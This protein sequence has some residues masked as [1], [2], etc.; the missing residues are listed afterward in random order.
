MAEKNEHVDGILEQAEAKRKALH[1]KGKDDIAASL[2]MLILANEVI[3]LRALV[4]PKKLTPEIREVLGHMVYDTSPLAHAFQD[5][6][7][8]IPRKIEEEQA[9]ILHKLIGY[10]LTHGANWRKEFTKELGPVIKQ[11][12]AAKKPA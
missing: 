8:D 12:K 5:A 10:A 7:V 4:W 1:A 11:A 2:S 9:F 3:R 6:G